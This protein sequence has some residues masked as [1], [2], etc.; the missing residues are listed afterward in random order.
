MKYSIIVS[1]ILAIFLFSGCESDGRGKPEIIS[2]TA[3]RDSLLAGDNELKETVITLKL[4]GDHLK[5]ANKII[6][7]TYEDE[8]GE[9]ITGLT[10]HKAR[11]DSA[12]VAVVSYI[13][14]T[15]EDT[16]E[17]PRKVTVYAEMNT[18]RTVNASLDFYIKYLPEED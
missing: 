3:T 5:I 10:N 6:N 8:Y 7:Y 4:S 17:N 2:F 1:I 11:T 18:Y 12:G 9:L 14:L 15:P 16:S 13:A